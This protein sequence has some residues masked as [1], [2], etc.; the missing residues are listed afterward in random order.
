MEKLTHPLCDW[1][2][3]KWRIVTLGERRVLRNGRLVLWQSAIPEAASTVEA[4]Y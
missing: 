3:S 4:C 1:V 2:R